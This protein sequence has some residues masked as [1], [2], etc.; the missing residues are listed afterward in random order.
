M[1]VQWPVQQLEI[2]NVFLPKHQWNARYPSI[3]LW[4]WGL[5]SA[6]LTFAPV[7]SRLPQEVKQFLTSSDTRYRR[8]HWLGIND[9]VEVL[10][11]VGVQMVVLASQRVEVNHDIFLHCD[12]VHH[13]DEVQQGL[14]VQTQQI[15]PITISARSCEMWRY[16]ALACLRATCGEQCKHSLCAMCMC[17]WAQLCVQK[18]TYWNKCTCMQN[19]C[20]HKGM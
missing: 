16:K 1:C 13:V 17:M 12:V 10:E 3:Q 7:C 20:R 19:R 8:S 5:R 4:V 11:E 2:I 15:A 14:H 18:R 6:A 9:V